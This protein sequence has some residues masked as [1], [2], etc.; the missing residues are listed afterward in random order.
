MSSLISTFMVTRVHAQAKENSRKL[1][2][3]AEQLEAV[4]NAKRIVIT[5]T[6]KGLLITDEDMHELEPRGDWRWPEAP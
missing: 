5:H 2:A 6:D 4:R 1:D 3:S